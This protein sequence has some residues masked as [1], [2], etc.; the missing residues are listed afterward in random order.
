[1]NEFEALSFALTNRCIF[2]NDH[3]S[4]LN[5][6]QFTLNFSQKN[7]RKKINIVSISA[8]QSDLKPVHICDAKVFFR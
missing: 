6:N 4:L 1:M 2:E 5:S 8:K 7:H 3:L